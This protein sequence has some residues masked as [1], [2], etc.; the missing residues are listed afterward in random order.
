MPK[1]HRKRRQ[2][3][4]SLALPDLEQ[5]KSAV[6]NSLTSKGGQ[7]TYDH[8]I[9]EFVDWYLWFPEINMG[10]E[11]P[12][13]LAA[14]YPNQASSEWNLRVIRV[15]GTAKLLFTV[16]GRRRRQR[17]DKGKFI[18]YAVSLTVEEPFQVVRRPGARSDGAGHQLPLWIQSGR[19][20]QVVQVAFQDN[21][22]AGLSA[23]GLYGNKPCKPKD[24]ASK[25]AR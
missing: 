25:C 12:G 22:S 2:P 23:F 19:V 4:R 20:R 8:A 1:H 15:C 14:V 17:I 5:T 9:N 24:G 11:E 7:R 21:P 6:L 16:P 18:N 13:A 10:S 3:K